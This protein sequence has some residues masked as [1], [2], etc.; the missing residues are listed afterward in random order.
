VISLLVCGEAHLAIQLFST[1]HHS[2]SM[3]H[4]AYLRSLE[5]DIRPMCD[6]FL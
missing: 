5:D 6:V 2:Q 3:S 4:L 1:C